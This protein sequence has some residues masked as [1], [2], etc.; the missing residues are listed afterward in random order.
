MHTQR[1]RRNEFRVL[2]SIQSR[3]WSAHRLPTCPRDS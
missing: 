1:R 3:T 2:L